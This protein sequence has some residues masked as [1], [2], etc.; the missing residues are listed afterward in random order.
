[1]ITIVLACAVS[2]PAANKVVVIPLNT[3]P[4]YGSPDKLWGQG[5]PGVGLLLHT[6][7][8]GYCTTADGVNYALSDSFATWDGAQ[9]ACPVDTWVCSVSDLPAD[10]ACPIQKIN[11]YQY[12]DCKGGQSTT[13]TDLALA[14]G[15]LSDM[16]SLPEFGK[17]YWSSN[18]ASHTNVASCRSQRVW[19]C[20][21]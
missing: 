16:H 2:A 12:R 11:S 3:T 17:L 5:R 19:C 13:Y 4:R 9:H 15:W 7:A 14:P 20:W 18:F 1:M 21:E 8:N 10:G 6:D